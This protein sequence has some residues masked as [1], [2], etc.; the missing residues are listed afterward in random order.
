MLTLKPAA[1][2]FIIGHWSDHIAERSA[3]P[4]G[5]D[6]KTRLQE[7][8]AQRRTIELQ[9]DELS[10]AKHRE[11]LAD[12]RLHQLLIDYCCTEEEPE[13]EEEAEEAA[14]ATADEVVVHAAVQIETRL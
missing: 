10:G 6:F 13:E 11:T 14:A 5:R 2:A 7:L 12:K 1:R 8:K 3:A 9:I 4:G